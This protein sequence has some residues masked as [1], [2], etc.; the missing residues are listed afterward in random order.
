MPLDGAVDEHSSFL[1]I[2]WSLFKSF[3]WIAVAK[4]EDPSTDSVHAEG[5]VD[6]EEVDVVEGGHGHHGQVQ[7]EGVD[8]VQVQNPR[9]GA[10]KRVKLRLK[11][12]R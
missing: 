6:V 5:L 4:V 2:G 10:R 3:P 1:W 9:L 11:V 8:E 7:G 12:Y